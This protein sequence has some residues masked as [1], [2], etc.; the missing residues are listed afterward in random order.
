MRTFDY[1]KRYEKLLQPDIVALVAQ[2]HEYKGKQMSFG[3]AKADALSQLL[4]VAKIQSTESSNKIEGIYTSEDRLK[5][6]VR[7]KTMPKTRSEKEIAGYRDVLNTIHQNYDYIPVKSSIFLQL[8]RELYKFAGSAGGGF[9]SADNVT[10]QEDGLGNKMIRVQSIPAWETPVYIDTICDAFQEACQ[11]PQYDPLILISMFILD[12]LCIHPFDDGNGRMSRLLTLLL[13]YRAGYIVGMYISIEKLIEQTKETY[14]ETL[15]ESSFHWHE[16]ENDD[17][18][19]VRYMLGVIV[20]AYRDFS[21]KVQFLA[22]SGM[23]KPERV[24][25]IVRSSMGKMTRAQ[26][27]EKCPDISR[28]TVERALTDMVKKGEVLK[29]GGGR[30]T[31]YAWNRENE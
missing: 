21:T 10:V 16:E 30:Y 14:Y 7:D 20:E 13:L 31:A 5:K 25:E 9:K 12:F 1:K 22:A 19:F 6:I 11:D 17:A 8:H 15:Q 23:S 28:V 2:I 29:I 3:E 4:E 26:I 18:P 27:M 24:R